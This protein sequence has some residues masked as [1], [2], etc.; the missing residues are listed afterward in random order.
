MRKKE[1]ETR[2]RGQ[3]ICPHGGRGGVDK[4]LPLNRDKAGDRRS[5]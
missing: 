2:K 1:K 5:T 3:D 4:G